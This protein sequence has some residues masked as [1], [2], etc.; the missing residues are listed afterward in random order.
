M[1]KSEF[2]EKKLCGGK[3]IYDRGFDR[4][5]KYHGLAPSLHISN[6]MEPMC[7]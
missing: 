4:L 2:N 5:K 6:K 1:I 3:G 7:I